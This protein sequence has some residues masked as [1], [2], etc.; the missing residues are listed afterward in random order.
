MGY[1]QNCENCRDGEFHLYE[2]SPVC[3]KCIQNLRELVEKAI[4]LRDSI[5]YIEQ[6]GS[7]L[8]NIKSVKALLEFDMALGE[9]QKDQNKKNHKKRRT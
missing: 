1:Y 3:L 5:E 6:E 9:Y 7:H 8:F 4:S 2:I